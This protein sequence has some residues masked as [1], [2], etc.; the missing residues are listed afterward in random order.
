MPEGS[1]HGTM[2]ES[3][4]P[5]FLFPDVCLGETD[6][7]AFDREELDIVIVWE[8]PDG[9]GLPGNRVGLFGAVDVE[10]LPAV[11]VEVT[12]RVD[13]RVESSDCIRT[14]EF[15]SLEDETARGMA[16]GV[17]ELLG[18]LLGIMGRLDNVGAGNEGV[19][20]GV[21]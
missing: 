4:G 20:K 1:L 19:R 14:E 11:L 9:P 5:A 16:I 15:G 10:E 21:S 18:L 3:N 2:L 12:G 17:D 6:S 8:I 7:S 13:E